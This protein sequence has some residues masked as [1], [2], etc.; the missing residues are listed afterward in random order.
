M[1]LHEV[2]GR[3]RDG[4]MSDSEIARSVL[5]IASGHGFSHPSPVVT[6]DVWSVAL[7]VLVRAPGVRLRW[8]VLARSFLDEIARGAKPLSELLAA[9]ATNAEPGP[10]CVLQERY[11]DLARELGAEAAPDA[12]AR[13]VE[14]STRWTEE[15]LAPGTKS[16]LALDLLAVVSERPSLSADSWLA[17][18]KALGRTMGTAALLSAVER[19][20]SVE[21][22][23]VPTLA[24]AANA[25]RHLGQLDDAKTVARR[26]IAADPDRFEGYFELAIVLMEENDLEGALRSLDS[27]A[28]RAASFPAE[29]ARVMFNR[30]ILASDLHRWHEA[31]DS[32]AGVLQVDSTDG[33]AWAGYGKALSLLD[34][35]SDALAAYEQ[36]LGDERLSIEERARFLAERSMVNEMSGDGAA[37]LADANEAVRLSAELPGRPKGPGIAEPSA[38]GFAFKVRG[39]LHLRLGDSERAA[40]DYRAALRVAPEDWPSRGEVTQRLLAIEGTAREPGS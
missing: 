38:D 19:A 24:L 25:F 10:S 1:S 15:A 21:P 6:A 11:R 5:G 2:V 13:A 23:H 37:A 33:I 3:L 12:I 9:L 32:F 26:T 17:I 20:V 29:W 18:A 40:A 39:D 31:A 34:R 28:E 22:D 36:A 4:G 27:A 30:A 7:G 16:D 35:Y 14:E 8:S